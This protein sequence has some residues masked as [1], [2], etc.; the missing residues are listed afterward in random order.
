MKQHGILLEK[1]QKQLHAA[2]PQ[3]LLLSAISLLFPTIDDT[4]SYVFKSE[5]CEIKLICKI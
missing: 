5:Y 2:M 4:T 3:S 1:Y